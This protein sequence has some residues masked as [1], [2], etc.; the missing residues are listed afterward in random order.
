MEEWATVPLLPLHTA[1]KELRCAA[2][3]ICDMDRD[4]QAGEEVKRLIGHLCEAVSALN[5]LT[6]CAIANLEAERSLRRLR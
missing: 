6:D 2:E 5:A 4:Q 3:A 1:M